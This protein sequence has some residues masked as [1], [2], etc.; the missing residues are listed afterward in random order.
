MCEPLHLAFVGCRD[1]ILAWA[2]RRSGARCIAALNTSLKSTQL[3]TCVAW[4]TATCLNRIG[5]MAPAREG[6]PQQ[7]TRA[8]VA[9]AVAASNL[10]RQ[11]TVW[12]PWY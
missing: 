10:A 3:E 9:E 11:E 1:D 8:L 2:A 12:C 6:H 5:N 4:N 7:G